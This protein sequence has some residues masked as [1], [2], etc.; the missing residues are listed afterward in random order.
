M[1][2]A[3]RGMEGS[4]ERAANLPFAVNVTSETKQMYGFFLSLCS[5]KLNYNSHIDCA[6]RKE[7]VYVRLWEQNAELV[8][9]HCSKALKYNDDKSDLYVL[10]RIM[11]DKY[12]DVCVR[13]RCVRVCVFMQNEQRWK[14]KSDL[15]K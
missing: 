2:I 8:L 11:S 7:S 14:K 9:E 12:Y 15:D 5:W 13:V 4:R 6:E 3:K 1:E 10:E